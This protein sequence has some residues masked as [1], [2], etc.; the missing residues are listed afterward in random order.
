MGSF[1]RTAFSAVL[2]LGTS[3]AGAG[4]ASALPLDPAV[5]TLAPVQAEKI[6]WVCGP[7]H[8]HP[9]SLIHI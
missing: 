8:C 7:F 2:L 9:L 1:A 6:G 4:Q 3:I 5:A